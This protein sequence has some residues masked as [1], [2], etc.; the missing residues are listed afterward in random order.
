MICVAI[1]DKDLKKCLATL[2]R[3]EL[4]EI[5]LD[6][7]EFDDEQIRKVFSHSTP[8][9]AS[10][11]PDKMGADEQQRRLI[12]AMEAGAR[13]VDIEYEASEAQRKTIIEFAKKKKCRIII[14]YHNFIRTPSRDELFRI[15]DT[16]FNMGADVAKV[17]T[18]ANSATDVANLLS[19][20]SMNRPLVS[21]GM[22][23]HGVITRLTAE[24]L[25][26]E[27]TF[28]AMDD[29]EATAPGQIGFQRMK[30]I[31]QYLNQELKVK[32]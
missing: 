6:L 3:C 9:V 30:A 26:A 31:L 28:A 19:L 12:L 11:R 22:G 23:E 32:K 2:D 25:G 4:A 10:C 17:A 8:A 13:Y 20:Y 27:F 24:F 5:R 7:T 15:A 18:Q 14:S 29:G 16:C 1:S 21:L